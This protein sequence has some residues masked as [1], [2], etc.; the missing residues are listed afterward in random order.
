MY[1]NGKLCGFLYL[2]QTDS[3]AEKATQQQSHIQV[4]QVDARGG[5]GGCGGHGGQGGS[6]GS[7]GAGGG[8][9]RSMFSSI[10]NG[11]LMYGRQWS[12]PIH[13]DQSKGN[14]AVEAAVSLLQAGHQRPYDWTGIGSLHRMDR[15]LHGG[16]GYQDRG[17]FIDSGHTNDDDGLLQCALRSIAIEDLG[18]RSEKSGVNRSYMSRFLQAGDG[19]LTFISIRNMLSHAKHVRA[20]IVSFLKSFLQA[21]FLLSMCLLLMLLL[22]VSVL[23]FL[24]S[25][26]IDQNQNK[27]GNWEFLN[28][29]ILKSEITST[30]ERKT[31]AGRLILIFFPAV[32]IHIKLF[33]N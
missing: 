13:K 11:K 33:A 2:G 26:V 29:T 12:A 20:K 25:L 32:N 5:A 21:P 4:V 18:D 17:L 22:V 16:T 7:G 31:F 19:K 27:N 1:F 15:S 8:G 30:L 9:G 10:S 14:F 28:H 3:H 23:P 6:G 24:L